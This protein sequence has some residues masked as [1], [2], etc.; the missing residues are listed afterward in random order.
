MRS[1]EHRRGS[2]GT[3]VVRR[4]L[5]PRPVVMTVAAV[6]VLAVVLVL[7]Q[8]VLSSQQASRSSAEQRFANG[9]VV[10]GQLT[11]ALLSTSS[12]SL[13]ASAP[14]LPPTSAALD[15]FAKTSRLGYAA[16]LSS[17]GDV[18][19][20]SS[21]APPAVAQRLAGRPAY[22]RQALSGRAWISRVMPAAR[23]GAD[24]I[25]L[26]A[27][28]T[29]PDGRRVLVEGVPVA[30]L[31]P[32]LTSFL[33]QGAS[34]RAI[35]VVDSQR[36]LI[37]AS[38]A[39]KVGTS[40]RLPAPLDQAESLSSRSIDG[41]FVASAGIAGTGWQIV[42]AQPSAT[43]YPGI[44]GSRS[45][46]LWAVVALAAVVGF[47]SLI[48]LRR[49]QERAA[50]LAAAHAEVTA[51]NETLEAKVA[52]RTELAER[53]AQALTRSN[54][55]LEQFASVA[56]HDLQEPLRKIRMYCQ[57]LERWQDDM[58]DEAHADVVRMEAAAGRMQNLISDLLDLARVNSRG[59]DP[60]AVDLTEIAREVVGD[61]EPP[62][63]RGGCERRHRAAPGRHRRPG[64][65]PSGPAE[66]DQQRPQVPPRGRAA[67]GPREHGD[68]QPGAGA[69]S[70]S[71]TTGSDST[72]STPSA[73]SAR[74]SACT[75]ARSTRARA[76]ASRSPA[77]SPGATT[78]TSRPAASPGKAP[79][80]RL[81]LPLAPSAPPRTPATTS[82]TRSPKAKGPR[83][84]D[85]QP[86]RRDDP[87]RRRRRGGSRDDDQRAARAPRRQR[88]PLRRRRRGVVRLPLQSRQVRECRRRTRSRA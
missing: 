53:R 66:P 76:S 64:P 68:E 45:W 63:R 62:H 3:S 73:S 38:K 70:P 69:S 77:R 79:S 50:Q 57:R 61:V 36:H 12:A 29:S 71:R 37:A 75:A 17:S 80:F 18:I 19:A 4:I 30:S 56:A 82:R 23:G 10:R 86:A 74:S 21:G 72:R 1:E 7:A 41:A 11:A 14:K 42:I 25:D 54:A 39:A 44:A 85:R 47:A 5:G 81:T 31:A 46:L 24:T 27:P 20:I 15:R 13:R 83:H 58:P 26:A 67:Q 87:A 9:A 51:L 52:E 43:L 6:S 8:L 2:G 35:Y 16:L 40:G 33:S 88:D 78:A 59:R 65:A 55:E 32:F 49:S 84:D 60:V 34:D 22:V 28:F 48:P